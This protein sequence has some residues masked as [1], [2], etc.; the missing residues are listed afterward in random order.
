MDIQDW[1]YPTKRLKNLGEIHNFHVIDLIKP[2]DDYVQENPVC[3]HGFKNTAMCTGHWN[4]T[5]HK[6][7]GEIIAEKS[8]QRFSKKF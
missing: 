7:A 2:F 5:G 8:W 4:A 6:L 3:F 1:S